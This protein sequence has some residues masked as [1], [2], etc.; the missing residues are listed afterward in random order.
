[1]NPVEAIDAPPTT[2]PDPDPP[3]AEQA[4]AI[5]TAAWADPGWGMLVWLAMVVGA[6]RGELCALRWEHVDLDGGF[7]TI[8]RAVAQQGARTWDKD[9]KTHQRRRSSGSSAPRRRCSPVRPALAG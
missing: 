5:S 2:P 4:A 9:T 1:V 6:R 8:R 3:T 7:L